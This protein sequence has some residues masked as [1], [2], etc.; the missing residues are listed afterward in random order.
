MFLSALREATCVWSARS[1][2]SKK[3]AEKLSLFAK[4]FWHLRK[5]SQPWYGKGVSEEAGRATSVRYYSNYI[6]WAT[7][8]DLACPVDFDFTYQQ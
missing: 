1:G 4:F 2:L 3:C 8:K 5:I 7:A 6:A